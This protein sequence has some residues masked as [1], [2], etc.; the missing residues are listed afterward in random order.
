MALMP[1]VESVCESV[2]VMNRGSSRCFLFVVRIRGYGA[3]V[4][5]TGLARDLRPGDLRQDH[6]P[7][8]C[9]RHADHEKCT[10]QDDARTGD[11][12]DRRTLRR[13]R[14]P[15]PESYGRS[16]REIDA[17]SGSAL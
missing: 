9:L 7:L 1:D 14:E 3:G 12:V 17:L 5:P 2:V 13:C 8:P 16:E 15:D 10:P 6:A 4:P 11:R